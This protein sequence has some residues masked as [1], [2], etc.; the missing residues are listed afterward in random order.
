MKILLWRE[1][2]ETVRG[3]MAHACHASMT[4]VTDSS[5][6]APSTS[7]EIAALARAAGLA[8][9]RY[10]DWAWDDTV[11]RYVDDHEADSAAWEAAYEQ[12]L[13][14][15]RR[16]V[17]GWLERWTIAPA[18]YDVWGTATL[19][20]EGTWHDRP[21]RR[22]LVQP[23]YERY[24]SDRYASGLYGTWAQ[25]PR[26]VERRLA[27][28]A[29]RE[30]VVIE[31][32]AADRAAGLSW[33]ASASD[34][35][36]DGALDRDDAPRGV[37]RDQ[38]RGELRRRTEDREAAACAAEYDR[39]RALVLAH[40]V[41]VDDGAPAQRSRWGVVPGRPS[42]V[43]YAVSVDDVPRDARRAA[44]RAQGQREDER[45][46]GDLELVAKRLEEGSL[47][48]ARAADIPPEPVLRR[49]GH[50]SLSKVCRVEAAGRVVWV[51]RSV[52]ARG[53]LIF[54]ERG[55]V[56]RARALVEVV[57]RSMQ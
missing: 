31:R 46:V 12:G 36:I 16:T 44:V 28:E 15:R 17:E 25:D 49:V 38:L 5:D 6:R 19:A 56:V 11:Q 37:E 30:R 8:G 3:G 20:T 22:V 57:E 55:R 9:R 52:F 29:A 32:R 2:D 45:R 26:E 40:E 42:R 4:Q 24:Q 7:V 54:D 27:E 1:L 51:H 39:C 14:E 50:E 41:L 13:L 48:G 35:E 43:Y 34:A 33:L 53:I 18:D 21:L 47:R 10:M 23:M